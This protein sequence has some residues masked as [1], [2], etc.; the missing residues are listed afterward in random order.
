MADRY[1]R[2]YDRDPSLWRERDEQ[3][4]RGQRGRPEWD[5]EG[6]WAQDR[7]QE[8]RGEFGGS[9]R[10][11]WGQNRGYDQDQERFAGRGGQQ[12][13]RGG[14]WYGSEQDEF[15]Q[16]RSYQGGQQQYGQGRRMGDQGQT[17]GRQQWGRGSQMGQG[18][19]GMDYNSGFG[20]GGQNWQG[21]GGQ[22][23]GYGQGQEGWQGQ[24]SG[25]PW[26][27]RGQQQWGQGGQQ[28][29]WQGQGQDWMQDDDTQMEYYDTP[30][31]YTYTEFWLIP[32]PFSGV[33]PENYT[34][35]PERL[36]EDV[37]QRLTQ[38]GHINAANI[39]VEVNDKCEVTLTGQVD[40]RQAKRLAEDVAESVWG[41]NDVHNQI[42]VKGR[43]KQ[44]SGQA[45]S[46]M[47]GDGQSGK[48]DMQSQPG[49]QGQSQSA[50]RGQTGTRSK[51]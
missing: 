24:R 9:T 42:R 47:Q 14:R 22:G 48:Q 16:G 36:R 49:Q 35:S 34:R 32:G 31:T 10:R 46:Q 20:R 33:G 27:Q 15:G 44:Q 6:G 1:D 41:V 21:R 13:Q 50:T 25:Q 11:G 19:Q 29:G 5:E 7:S 17:Q 4:Q 37:I 2:E 45:A 51:S 40:D 3:G 38:H 18:S 12:G 30:V 39:N 8:N 28:Q 23:R 43:D 26:G